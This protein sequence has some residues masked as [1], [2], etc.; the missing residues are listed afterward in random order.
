MRA[1]VSQRLI[2][3]GIVGLGLSGMASNALAQP[4]R[5]ERNV[6]RALA[7]GAD[8]EEPVAFDRIPDEARDAIDYERHREK[9]LATF[10]IRRSGAD[11]IRATVKTPRSERVILVTAAGVLKNVED[12]RPS[13]FRDYHEHQDAWYRDYDDRMIATQRFYVH[14]AEGVTATVDHPE[15]VEWDRC[16]GRVRVTMMRESDGEK[17][18]YIIRYR[19]HGE[20]IYQV[21]IPDGGNKHHLLQIRPDGSIFNEG[22][23]TPAGQVHGGDWRAHT[24]GFDDLP[25]RVRET[26]DRVAPHA[27]IPLVQVARRHDRDIFSVEI[28]DR[29][30][31]RY[32]T[33][34][35]DGKAISDVSDKFEITRPR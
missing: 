21:N 27:R 33:L 5:I 12:V 30:G 9:V 6:D 16:P 2:W 20:V 35:Q 7:S 1:T 8:F 23:Y 28:A 19:D 11:Y 25:P 14:E 10:R 18:D 32:L 31:T 17:I 24:I 4:R 29:D 22:E 15:R 3:A 26:L 13:E 34:N